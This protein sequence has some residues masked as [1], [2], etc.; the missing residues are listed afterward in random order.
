MARPENPTTEEQNRHM[1]L[2]G[3]QNVQSCTELRVSQRW[4]VGVMPQNSG[5]QTSPQGCQTVHAFDQ[6]CFTMHEDGEKWVWVPC[7]VLKTVEDHR[8][9]RLTFRFV[10]NLPIDVLQTGVTASFWQTGNAYC[11]FVN[12]G[13]FTVVR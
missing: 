2:T 8:C 6:S 7:S 10:Q 11:R 13:V 3:R 1:E 5:L 9:R 4:L 12:S